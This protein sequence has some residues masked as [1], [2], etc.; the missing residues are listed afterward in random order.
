[1]KNLV[2]INCEYGQQG[3]KVKLS[4]SSVNKIINSSKRKK[5]ARVTLKPFN[6]EALAASNIDEKVEVPIKTQPN[7]SPLNHLA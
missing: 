6:D 4:N 3:T 7:G 2:R 1:M 5:Q